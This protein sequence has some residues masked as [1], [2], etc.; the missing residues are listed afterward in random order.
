MI[1]DN[2]FE[3]C[4][5]LTSV[6]IPSG[7]Q[8]IGESAFEGCISIT[9]VNFDI[10]STSLGHN[11]GSATIKDNAFLGCDN[12]DTIIVRGASGSNLTEKVTAYGTWL[13]NFVSSTGNSSLAYNNA[14]SGNT[15]SCAHFIFRS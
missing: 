15:T 9:T 6:Y 4:I 12:I 11:V 2:A 7:V 10:S 3:E 8:F 5:S 14:I 1:D 13:A